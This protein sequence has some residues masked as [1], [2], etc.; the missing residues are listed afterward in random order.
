[1]PSTSFRPVPQPIT[2]PHVP[3]SHRPPGQAGRSREQREQRGQCVVHRGGGNEG[4]GPGRNMSSSTRKSGHRTPALQ[5]TS[6]GQVLGT[7]A[8][9]PREPPGTIVCQGPA[10]GRLLWLPTAP[11]GDHG[12]A[13]IVPEEVTRAEAK[14]AGAE[15]YLASFCQRGA[16]APCRSGVPASPAA[17]PT[18]AGPDWGH[19]SPS[20]GK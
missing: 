8:C 13:T 6:W 20:W 14:Q 16:Q 12:D 5:T 17:A 18:R 4:R 2:V 1:M 7:A 9:H 15:M 11:A 10:K 19:E 3:Q